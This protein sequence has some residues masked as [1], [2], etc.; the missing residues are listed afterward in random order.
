MFS[1]TRYKARLPM[2]R[3]AISIFILLHA[4]LTFASEAPGKSSFFFGKCE[5]PFDPV[6]E[7]EAIASSFFTCT[8]AKAFAGSLYVPSLSALF[9]SEFDVSNSFHYG[10]NHSLHFDYAYDRIDSQDSSSITEGD[11]S[12]IESALYQFGNPAFHKF[13]FNLGIQ[14]PAFGI[15]QYPNLGYE[16]LFNPEFM[17][18]P[19]KLGV[20]LIYDSQTDTQVELGWIPNE[21]I[22][23]S[24]ELPDSWF[25]SR[26]MYDF[27]LNG[28]TRS[29][30]SFMMKKT[31]EKRISLGFVSH[32][33]NR[34]IL[35]AEWTRIYSTGVLEASKNVHRSFQLGKALADAPYV[36]FMRL[37]YEDPPH[38]TT[39][40]FFEYNLLSFQYR[41]Y[42][43]GFKFQFLSK[44]LSLRLSLAFKQDITPEK[45]NRWLL[46]GGFGMRL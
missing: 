31:G 18:L 14:R 44:R 37:A 36:Q 30:F 16:L 41:L 42:S 17:W 23:G 12:R 6:Q 40:T 21:Q 7:R 10:L 5:L 29:I 32:G 33:S 43:L 11:R 46:G 15:N 13:R 3:V 38:R 25:T 4:G 27:T 26:F 2:I 9:A 8:K 34:A 39:R 19:P 20:H 28:T 22:K 45:Q 24:L 1:D 35:Q